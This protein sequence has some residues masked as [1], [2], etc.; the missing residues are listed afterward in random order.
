[1]IGR[2]YSPR[3]F[4]AAIFVPCPEGA[5][6]IQPRAP[7]WEPGND[8]NR[9]CP[10]AQQGNGSWPQSLVQNHRD[11][12]LGWN[13]RSRPFQGMGQ[14]G[15]QLPRRCPGRKRNSTDREPCKGGTTED[16]LQCRSR[17]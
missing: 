8:L 15:I 7:P 4:C 10:E 17:S 3:V 2:P 5:A 16:P 14:H 13:A 6:T 12:R 1:M 11:V 9:Q